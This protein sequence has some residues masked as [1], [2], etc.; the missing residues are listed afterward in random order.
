[1]S[2]TDSKPTGDV[3]EIAALAR[4]LFD[5]LETP[6]DSH[7]GARSRAAYQ[8]LQDKDLAAIEAALTTERTRAD[9]AESNGRVLAE[10]LVESLVMTADAKRELKELREALGK[11]RDETIVHRNAFSTWTDSWRSRA[12]FV[13][14][15]H[16]LLTP[17][18]T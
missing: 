4:E 10:K 12:G 13:D 15:L 5:R 2:T 6:F 18:A 9:A 7:S 1:M 3:A 11:L 8:V 17:E 16:A 14:K